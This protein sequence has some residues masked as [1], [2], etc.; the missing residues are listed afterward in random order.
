MNEL[1]SHGDVRKAVLLLSGLTASLFAYTIC[2]VV[3]R[4][5]MHPLSKIPGPKHLVAFDIF[6]MYTTYVSLGISQYVVE[7]HLKYGPMVRIGPN[8]V[9]VD[10]SIAWSQ[11]YGIRSTSESN[12]FGKIPGYLSNDDH[13]SVIA[14]SRDV[15]R[16]QRRQISQAFSAASIHEQ[17]GI[18]KGYIQKL[19]AEVDSR[20]R[21]QETFDMVSWLNYTTFDI[22]GDLIFS[23]SFGSLDGDTEFVDNIFLGLKGRALSLFLHFF[24][25]MKAPLMLLVGSK[26]LLIAQETGVANERL[27]IIKAQDRMD[28]KMKES[29]R[30]DFASYLLRRGK[31]GEEILTPKEV[32]MNSAFLVT[33]G[34]ETTATALSG[35]LFFLSRSENASKLQRVVDDVCKAFSD[36][37]AIDMTST[38][39]LQYLAAVIEES[40]RMYPPVASFTPRQSPG[41]EVD[42]HWLPKGTVV[43][44]NSVASYRNPEYFRD[45]D[46]FVP[47]RWLNASHPLHISRYDSDRKDIFKPFSAGSHDCVGKNLAYAEMRTILARLLFRFDFQVLPGQD[48]WMSKQGSSPILWIKDGLDVRATLR[49]DLAVVQE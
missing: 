44:F 6:N 3:Y 40:L 47:E 49:K 9:I 28:G 45:P 8:R 10:G 17:E 27:G 5:W 41:A 39:H 46:T 23:D 14:A 34:S 12:D 7:L 1:A 2:T 36:E 11:I 21:K 32:M 13:F 37:S 25:L 31:D 20:A 4:I 15:H 22:I 16:R 35:A 30:R 24:P 48:D 43:H 26:E 18:I 19:I 29:S 38:A 42:G 33:A